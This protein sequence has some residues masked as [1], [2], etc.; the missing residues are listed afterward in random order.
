MIFQRINRGDAEKVFCVQQN[1]S[2]STLAVNTACV[3]DTS[4][5]ADGVRVL[6][7][8]ASTLS[9]IVGITNAAIAD[10]AYGLVQTYGFRATAVVNRDTTATVAGDI[11]VPIASSGAM[12]R[13]GGSAADGYSGFV[14]AGYAVASTNATLASTSKVFIRCL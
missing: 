9:C 5:S 7:P 14:T 1:V 11:L 6:L 13:V 2:G 4:T 3:W 10:S 12:T 8:L